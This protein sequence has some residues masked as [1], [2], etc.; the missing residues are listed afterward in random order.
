MFPDAFV[1]STLKLF[2]NRAMLLWEFYTLRGADQSRFRVE[3]RV[4]M[5]KISRDWSEDFFMNIATD[6]GYLSNPQSYM[7]LAEML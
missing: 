3:M 5:M 7:V 6:S 1:E 2:C 4:R